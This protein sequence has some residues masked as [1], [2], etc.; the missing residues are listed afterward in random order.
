MTNRGS[1]VQQQS[2]RIRGDVVIDADLEFH[3]LVEGDV[4][5]LSSASFRL[6]GVVAGSLIVEPG[7]RAF[8]SGTVGHDLINRGFA[9]VRGHVGKLRAEGGVTVVDTGAVV[10]EL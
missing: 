1:S 2:S 4:R 6:S 10:H 3:G 5:V 8:I 9:E 7:A